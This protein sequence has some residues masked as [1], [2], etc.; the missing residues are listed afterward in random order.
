M[1]KYDMTVGEDTPTKNVGAKKKERDLDG[2]DVD[3]EAAAG[4][5]YVGEFAAHVGDLLL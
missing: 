2:L 3:L 4:V 1:Q 5:A